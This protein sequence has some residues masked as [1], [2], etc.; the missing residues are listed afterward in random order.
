[1][2]ELEYKNGQLG[3]IPDSIDE[4]DIS[5]DDYVLG[6]APL[7]IDW[8]KGFDIR[9]QLG[10]DIKLKLQGPSLSCVGQAISY[11]VW[12]KQVIEMM[13]RYKMSLP[14]L[15]LKMPQEV[16]EVSPRA[17]Y[18]QIYQSPQ[19]G[20][21]IRDGMKLVIDWGSVFEHDVP[22]LNP[23][24]GMEDEEWMR[25]KDW[26]NAN[27]SKIASILKGQKYM[28]IVAASNMDLFARAIIENAGVVG[29]I[30]G[31]NGQGWSTENPSPPD[32]TD[33]TWGH[34]LFYGAFGTDEKGRFIATPN[35]WGNG[36]RSDPSY[37]WKPGDPPGKGWQKLRSNYFNNS[38]QFNPWT[39]QDK[40]NEEKN[41][42]NIKIIKDSKSPSVGIWLP[43]LSPEAIESY[44]QNFG[45][46]VPKKDNGD[47][48]WEKFI[49]GELTLK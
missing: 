33:G 4:R 30:L 22:S 44:C 34:A 9:N 37:E 8:D 3:A 32:S 17:I 6:A 31:K 16:D 7:E 13:S 24:T 5:Y 27:I 41:M 12:V 10:A 23:S 28:N 39:L 47:I 43:A 46:N 11:Y 45:I 19:G 40:P 35:S 48:D 15:R 49:Q 25:N 26:L 18:A 38:V 42:S 20:A 21:S 36:Y 2:S 29:G 14:E 1:M